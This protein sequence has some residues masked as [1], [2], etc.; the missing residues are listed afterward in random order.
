MNE[1]W[2]TNFSVSLQ[3]IVIVEKICYTKEME[4]VYRENL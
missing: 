4:N 1:K 2:I 3:K